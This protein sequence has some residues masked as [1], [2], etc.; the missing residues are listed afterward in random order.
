MSK[1]P[2][3]KTSQQAGADN[4][5][6]N[7]SRRRFLATA[8]VIGAGS[9]G[10][11]PV[12]SQARGRQTD[13]WQP[14]QQFPAAKQNNILR[15]HI[16]NVIV[17]YA[18]NRSFNNLFANFPGTQSA[19]AELPAAQ[20][21]QRDRDGSLLPYLPPIWGGMV[22]DAQT[23][24]HTHYQIKQDADYLQKLAN[25]P[26]TLQGPEQEA[27]PQGVV[28]RDLCH[29]FYHNQMQINDGK[30]DKFAAWSDSGALTMGYYGDNKHN[31]RLWKLAQQY[32]LCD[33]FFQGA[34]GGSF[35][36]HQY[37]ICAQ[38]PF[39][40]DVSS[41]PA[42]GLI[43]TLMSD[44]PTDKRLKPLA[45]SPSSALQ[46]PPRFGP[47]QI[48]PDGYAVNTM[49]PPYW[50]SATRDKLDPALADAKS[51]N[52]LPPQTHP[53]IG[54][55]LSAKGIDWAWYAGGWQFANEG[56]KDS[57][58]FPPCP[59]FQTHHQPFNYFENLGPQHAIK[60]QHHLRDGGLGD[61]SAHNKFI[62][63]I[64][65]GHLPAVTF[66]KPQGNLNMHAGYS[67]V[68]A[69]DRHIA[70][71]IQKL[72]ESPLWDQSVIVVTFDENGGWWDPV[73]PPAGDRFGPGSRIPT[74]VISPF[75][76][77]SHVEHTQYDTGSI[78]RLISRIYDLP[79]LQGIKLR[80]QQLVKQGS[81]PM[82]D[83]T[84][85]LQFPAQ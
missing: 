26:F 65:A 33:N 42:R 7:P 70:H 51:A 56:K 6:D 76:R 69:G 34:F 37:L 62:N 46:G 8:S 84:E 66:Y 20:L 39:Y 47:A 48:T 32:T 45:D 50:P 10:L 38:P 43:A 1:K 22:P 2:N 80:D 79:K 73:A 18:E 82:G 23:V 60:R 36:N 74:L 64:E 61:N 3:S 49:Q 54:D 83:L 13:S 75:A 24:N 85:T 5:P 14:L 11:L 29:L 21:Q 55:L 19:L 31:L 28:T 16:R 59:D 68:G 15:K 17:I 44:D 27:L 4:R 81:K 72:Q 41:S 25:R 67:D 12:A 9:C 53:H 78:L 35:L 58:Q 57:T 30:N 71:I 40:P 63:D 52:T 77:K